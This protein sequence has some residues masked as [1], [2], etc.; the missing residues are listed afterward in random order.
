MQP[1]YLPW[2]GFFE[3]MYNCQ[4][5]VLLD[6]VQYTKKD[7][8]SRNK[9]RT[10]DGWAWLTVPVISKHYRLQTIKEAKIDNTS[11]WRLKHLKSFEI[12]YNK[13]A[14][15]NRYFPLLK[16]I[17]NRRWNFLVDLDTEI[18]MLFAKQLGIMTP[19]THS[20]LLHTKGGREERI[21]DICAKMG[22]RELYDSKAAGSILD[23]QDFIEAGIDIKF[24]D[25]SHP[26]Y[27]QVY[28][29]FIAYMSIVDLLFNCG[30]DSL[31]IL[32][33]KQGAVRKAQ[34]EV[35]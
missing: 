7:W 34:N 18:I 31:A 14:Y 27:K 25:Y 32:L 13:A 28:Q 26:E 3:L 24:Q 12:N 30:S 33:S 16:E 4:K 11:N 1:G 19:V 6:D 35:F 5:F 2:L 8:R 23:L 15:F 29:P 17:Y 21:I 10:K 20:S 22:A 9:I